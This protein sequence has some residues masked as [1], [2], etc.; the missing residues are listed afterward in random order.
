MSASRGRWV[1]AGAVVGAAIAA[2]ALKPLPAP[3]LL[4]LSV[5]AGRLRAPAMPLLVPT[6]A[7]ATAALL[8]P[9]PPG[10]LTGALPFLPHGDDGFV[11]L[12]PVRL[13]EASP[14]A[15]L[16]WLGVP[17]PLVGLIALVAAGAGVV[18]AYRRRLGTAPGPLRLAGKGAGRMLSA[19]LLCGPSYHHLLLVV[20][21]LLLAGLPYPGSAARRPGPGGP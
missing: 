9:D 8:M 10:F 14:A 12:C 18:C 1:T 20:L 16:P 11:L 15:L 6:F 17:W 21:P 3:L 4:L 19:F 2:I 5:F 13:Y 7:S